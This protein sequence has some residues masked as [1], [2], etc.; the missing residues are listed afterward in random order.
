MTSRAGV[1]PARTSSKT[2]LTVCPQRQGDG[3]SDVR[4][5]APEFQFDEAR[6]SYAIGMAVLGAGV[7][8]SA[9]RTAVVPGGAG[10]SRRCRGPGG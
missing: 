5:L 10:S 2:P 4:A 7:P 1:R 9:G 8:A 3:S 6:R